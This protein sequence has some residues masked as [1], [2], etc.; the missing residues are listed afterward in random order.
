MS[1]LPIGKDEA[2]PASWT[3]SDFLRPRPNPQS[4]YP[5][6]HWV[7]RKGKFRFWNIKPPFIIKRGLREPEYVW[8]DYIEVVDRYHASSEC[9]SLGQ[10]CSVLESRGMLVSYV[11]LPSSRRDKRWSWSWW[12]LLLGEWRWWGDLPSFVY[13]WL[14]WCYYYSTWW[15]R[16]D[17]ALNYDTAD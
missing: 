4:G 9:E 13:H 16:F 8:N 14:S 10:L 7:Y 1:S 12:P 5:S 3:A 17:S 11:L 2:I 15:S 6:R